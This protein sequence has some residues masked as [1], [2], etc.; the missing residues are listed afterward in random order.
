MILNVDAWMFHLKMMTLDWFKLIDT[1]TEAPVIIKHSIARQESGLLTFEFR[2]KLSNQMDDAEWELKGLDKIG[3]IIKT[4]QSNLC[5]VNNENNP[6]VIQIYEPGIEYGIKVVADLS[7]KK[8]DIYVDGILKK[9]D[10]KFKEP[11][12]KKI[13]NKPILS[14]YWLPSFIANMGG[15]EG[16]CNALNTLRQECVKAGFDGVIVMMEERNA[17]KKKIT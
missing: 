8:M 16:A 17:D 12:Y 9:S 6:E 13:D 7:S 11:W 14:I 4:N 2:F 1:S 10:V 5:F 15:T 3:I